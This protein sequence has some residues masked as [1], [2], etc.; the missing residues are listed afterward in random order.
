MSKL[1]E[2]L[3]GIPRFELGIDEV[4]QIV[5]NT[6]KFGSNEFLRVPLNLSNL[7]GRYGITYL[8]IAAMKELF[9]ERIYNADYFGAVAE[10]LIVLGVSEGGKIFGNYIVN[11]ADDLLYKNQT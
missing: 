2:I 3:R 11:F 6:P 8:E 5:A 10:V 9:T 4:V 1:V 7:A